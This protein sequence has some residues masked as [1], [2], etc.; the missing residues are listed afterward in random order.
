MAAMCAGFIRFDERAYRPLDLGDYP[1]HAVGAP[2]KEEGRGERVPV[3]SWRH[4]SGSKAD[5][6]VELLAMAQSSGP[7]GSRRTLATSLG[8][9]SQVAQSSNAVEV[10]SEFLGFMATNDFPAVLA[11]LSHELVLE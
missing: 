11:V 10:L 8:A 7:L 5:D 1:D 9:I 6:G 4:D 3:R 2:L